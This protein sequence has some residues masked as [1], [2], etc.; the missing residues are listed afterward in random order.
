VA[1]LSILLTAVV[2]FSSIALDARV[3]NQ[4][5]TEVDEQ[6]ARLMDTI[7]QAIRNATSVTA[8]VSGVS[9]NQLTLVVPTGSL[10]PTVFNLS[11]TAQGA[12]TDG[13]TTDTS[14][15]NSIEA[16]KFTASAS[17]TISSLS[18]FVNTV[19]A[20]SS[21][22]KAQMAIYRGATPTTL[23][24]SS[25]STTLTANTWNNFT[26]KPVNVTSGTVY[27]LTYNTNGSATTDNDLRYAT[28]TS[29]Q[30]ATLAQAFGNWP[31][32]FTGTSGSKNYSMYAM[33]DAASTPGTLNSKEGTGAVTG[34][35]DGN[36]Q[37]SGLNFRNLSR[38]GTT[39]SI[40]VTFT[41]GRLNPTGKNE[42]DY[43]KTFQGSAEVGY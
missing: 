23:L 28:G 32:S 8:P 7:T 34:L 6:G 1:L 4:T 12:T 13:G 9:A 43:V 24:A 42:Y 10:S 15:S 25:A 37:V 2:F 19:N 18:A 30:S 39:G 33:V 14:N 17:G 29:G 22:N 5:I 31:A 38:S 20:S 16:V 11:G 40:Q 26:I 35:T 3:K 27:W 36:V 41:L 21:N